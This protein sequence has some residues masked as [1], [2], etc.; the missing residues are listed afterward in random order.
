M[1]YVDSC[2]LLEKLIFNDTFSISQK[3]KERI[4]IEMFRE[5]LENN[6]KNIHIK[7]MY[8]KLN[9]NVESFNSLAEIPFIPVNMFKK[10]DLY[11]CSREDIVRILNSSGTTTGNPSKIYVDKKTSLHQTQALM[12]TLRDFLGERRRPLLIIDCE[13]EN[14]KSSNL[15]ARGAAIRGIG[16]FSNKTVY[17][18]DKVGDELKPNLQRIKEFEQGFCNEEVLVYGFTYIIWSKFIKELQAMG[19]SINLTNSKIL[20]SGGWKK[21]TLQRVT[22][23]EFS[24]VVSEAFNTKE[25]DVIDFY[26]M[27]EQLGVIFIDCEYGYKHVPSFAEV[28]LRDLYTLEE[29]DL[30]GVGLIEVMSSLSSSYPAQ[31]V[32]TEDIGEFVGVDDCKCGRKG[33]YFKFKSRVE[34]SETRGCGDTFAERERIHD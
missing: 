10:F 4:L 17:A 24:K 12:A 34:K 1:S 25:R 18:F 30:G 3:E 29:V 16:N 8:E 6:K 19:E 2:T 23:E 20:H 31:A 28:I 22:K 5:Q 7:A 9:F 21:L 32:L 33:K 15:S 26:G 13:E 27:V 14:S 11:S